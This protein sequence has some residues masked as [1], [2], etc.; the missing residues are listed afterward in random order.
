MHINLYWMFGIVNGKTVKLLRW[1]SD[2]HK[3]VEA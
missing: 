1:N 3:S 2:V